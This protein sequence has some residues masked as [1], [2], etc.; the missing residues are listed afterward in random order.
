LLQVGDVDSLAN[1][2]HKSNYAKYSLDKILYKKP[3]SAIFYLYVFF[4]NYA[5]L[6]TIT[7]AFNVHACSQGVFT[8]TSNNTDHK[9]TANTP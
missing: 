2:F 4:C 9:V 3:T 6:S 1:G 7:A 8:P 5:C